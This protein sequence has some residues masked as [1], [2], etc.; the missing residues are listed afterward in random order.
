MIPGLYIKEFVVFHGERLVYSIDDD[1]DGS[2]YVVESEVLKTK[3][4]NRKGRSR[5]EVINSMLVNQEM[6]EDN[7]LL[8]ALDVYLNTVHLFEENLNIL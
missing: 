8:E 2:A 4:F 6:R 1:I 3:A 5:F 7:E